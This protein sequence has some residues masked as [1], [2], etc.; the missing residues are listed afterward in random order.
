MCGLFI[1]QATAQFSLGLK[2]GYT[3][4]LQHYGDVVL[5]E[6]GQRHI[7]GYQISVPVNYRLTSFLQIGLEPGVIRRGAACL[8]GW[9]WGTIIPTDL[10]DAKFKLDYTEIPLTVSYNVDLLKDKLGVFGKIGYGV[11]YLMKGTMEE[12]LLND[13]TAPI[14]SDVTSQLNRF[15]HGFYGGFGVYHYL[16]GNQIFLECDFY[17]SPLNVDKFN[18]SKNRSLDISLGYAFVL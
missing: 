12:I 18:V 1:H 13:A 2:S 6:D 11:S 7:N 8:P 17:R 4:S 5:P 14:L 10:Y 9:N 16:K 15:E 3:R